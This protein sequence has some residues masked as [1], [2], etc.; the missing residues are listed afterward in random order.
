MAMIS[1]RD[2][3]LQRVLEI[4]EKHGWMIQAVGADAGEPVFQYTVGLT[5]LQHP[6]FI[7]FGLPMTHGGQL[8]N[9][10]GNLVRAGR[11]FQHGNLVDGLAQDGYRALLVQVRDTKEHLTVANALFGTVDPVKALQVVFGDPEHRWP[12]QSDSTL[13]ALPILGDVPDESS[14]EPVR[15]KE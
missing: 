11:R 10:L 12:W 5:E 4:I 1:S 14:W 8:L 3:Y 2:Q 9:D 13:T 7:I 6:E 15:L